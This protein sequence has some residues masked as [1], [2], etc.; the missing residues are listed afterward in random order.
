M[1]VISEEN[2]KS[3]DNDADINSK[4][5]SVRCDL[6]DIQWTVSVNTGMKYLSKLKLRIQ[7]P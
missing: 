1:I 2:W 5:Q 7:H 6:P 3:E 4:Y